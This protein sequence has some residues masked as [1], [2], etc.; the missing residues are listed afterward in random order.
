[1]AVKLLIN[2]KKEYSIVQCEG[3]YYKIQ[4]EKKTKSGRTISQYKNRKN[5]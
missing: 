3:V 4:R 5:M 1:M 2:N